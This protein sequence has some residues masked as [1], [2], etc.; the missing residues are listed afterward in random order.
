MIGIISPH[1]AQLTHLS[2]KPNAVNKIAKKNKNASRR[3]DESVQRILDIKEKYGIKDTLIKT[4]DVEK[5]NEKI[6]E[7][8]NIAKGNE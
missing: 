7:I 2:K 6:D 3:I 5:I 8:N 1:L 4:Y